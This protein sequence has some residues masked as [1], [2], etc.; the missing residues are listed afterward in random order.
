MDRDIVCLACGTRLKGQTGTVKFINPS[1]IK[2]RPPVSAPEKKEE[3]PASPHPKESKVP[4]S[5][6]DAQ[7]RTLLKKGKKG[8]GLIFRLFSFLFLLF[9]LAF[10]G[11]Y[12]FYFQAFHDLGDVLFQMKKPS[13]C[14]AYYS[15]LSVA[16]LS[17]EQEEIQFRK[18]QALLE[19]LSMS[20]AGKKSRVDLRAKLLECLV[21]KEGLLKLKVN[22]VN[23]FDFALLLQD[24]FFYLKTSDKI[25]PAIPFKPEDCRQMINLGPSKSI[26]LTFAFAGSSVAGTKNF[27]GNLVFNDGRKY[28]MN[29]LKGMLKTVE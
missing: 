25:S 19:E 26:S 15:F 7:M 24:K 1:G 9:T 18:N 23:G 21:S 8:P 12:F 28:A 20:E 2:P 29:P 10:S 6:S 16:A 13:C 5:L 4:G 3:I 14:K 11:C 27:D 17:K 22:L